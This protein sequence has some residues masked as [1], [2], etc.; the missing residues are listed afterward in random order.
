MTNI[1]TPDGWERSGPC[2]TRVY[3]GKLAVL[4]LHPHRDWFRARVYE[5]GAYEVSTERALLLPEA[6]AWANE[7][8]GVPKPVE[9]VEIECED[10][11]L[12]Y[13]DDKSKSSKVHCRNGR[14]WYV[15]KKCSDWK[16]TQAEAIEAARA[17]VRGDA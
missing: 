8:L 13:A 4:Q 15:M 16:P 2:F 14:W 3:G 17:Y 11:V 9:V 6:V 12:L 5:A 10:G 7:Q 1:E